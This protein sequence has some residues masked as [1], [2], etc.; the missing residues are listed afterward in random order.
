MSSLSHYGFESF[1]SEQELKSSSREF[2]PDQCNARAKKFKSRCLPELSNGN[3]AN[4]LI[5]NTDMRIGLQHDLLQNS[6]DIFREC[7]LLT[8]RMLYEFRDQPMTNGQKLILIHLI[9]A[10]YFVSEFSDSLVSDAHAYLQK[11]ENLVGAFPLYLSEQIGTPITSIPKLGFFGFLWESVFQCFLRTL[12]TSYD[13]F[14]ARYPKG[15]EGKEAKQKDPCAQDFFGDQDS[16]DESV[17]IWRSLE[18]GQYRPADE[19]F[20]GCQVTARACKQVGTRDDM[21][22]LLSDLRRIEDPTG[23]IVHGLLRLESQF[24]ASKMFAHP[25]KAKFVIQDFYL[26][27][28][29]ETHRRRVYHKRL[30]AHLVGHGSKTFQEGSE[31]AWTL[32]LSDIALEGG[33]VETKVCLELIEGA[34]CLLAKNSTGFLSALKSI[35]V[36]TVETHEALMRDQVSGGS[37][38]GEGGDSSDQMDTSD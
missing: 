16:T 37:G 8:A 10:P 24:L 34:A 36:M 19:M 9:K 1:M 21:T 22:F 4:F 12:S 25:T 35:R 33:P 32:E 31:V 2:S 17:Q 5:G 38:V 3:T 18:A 23:R 6:L 13:A 29:P 27:I 28:S 15:K 7:R 11:P 26:D 20:L 30:H 14:G